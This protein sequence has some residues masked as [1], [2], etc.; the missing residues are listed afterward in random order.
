MNV[1]IMPPQPMEDPAEHIVYV[2]P[3]AGN[4]LTSHQFLKLVTGKASPSASADASVFG[5]SMGIF[6]DP[7]GKLNQNTIPAW[8]SR[9]GQ[10]LWMNVSGAVLA[11]THLG[12]QFGLVVTNGV[13]MVDL[14]NTTEKIFEIVELGPVAGQ[15][16]L[17]GIGDTNA[18]VL[19]EIIGGAAQ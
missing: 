10:R 4:T 19:V 17:G 16:P 7:S 13:A 6:P 1:P 5:L 9:V 18:R 15:L 14:T 2:A 3:T 8:R 11:Q 12:G